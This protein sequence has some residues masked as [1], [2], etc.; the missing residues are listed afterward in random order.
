VS[1]NSQSIIGNSPALLTTLASARKVAKTDLSVL[2]TGESGTGKELFARYVHDQSHREKKTFVAVN[3]AAIPGELLEAELFGHKKG[4]FSGAVC[5]RD[6]LF[7][8]ANGGTLFLD[9]IGDM[10]LTLQA[11]IL[12]VLQEGEVRPVGATIVKKVNVRIVSATHCDLNKMAEKKEFRED[13]IYRLKGYAL[14][15]PPLRDR[16]GDII[17]LATTFLNARKEFFSKIISRDAKTLL[18]AHSWP[19]NIRELQNTIL[20]AA[21]DAP[22]SIG[23]QHLQPHFMNGVQHQPETSRSREDCLLAAVETGGRLTLAQLHVSL[24]IP[25]PT[26]HRHLTQMVIDGMVHR[27]TDGKTV[28]FAIGDKASVGTEAF[29]PSR[30]EQAIHIAKETGRITRKQFAETI[31]VSIRTAGRELADMVKMGILESDGQSGKWSGY[32]VTSRG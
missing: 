13:L 16:M 5:D 8:Q 29:L 31:G 27:V 10:P 6:G 1:N 23:A 15:L 17:T 14:H 9:E 7:M 28:W 18:L 30:Q 3:C 26:L 2:I 19:G 12:R 21:V 24:H 32:I 11:K 4:A 20:A 25:K 22:K